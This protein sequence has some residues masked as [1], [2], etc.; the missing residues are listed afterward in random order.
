MKLIRLLPIVV[1]PCLAVCFVGSAAVAAF[2]APA[3]PQLGDSPPPPSPEKVERLRQAPPPVVKGVV[4]AFTVTVTTT[5]REE[6]R[7]F[8]NAVYFA[9]QDVPIAWSGNVASCLAGSTFAAFR[10]A[11][12]RR[13][14]YFRAM[15]GIPANIVFNGTF[16]TK[17]QQA[18]LMMSAANTLSHFPAPSWPCFTADGAEAAENSNL[19]LGSAGPDAVDGF[20]E[21][22]GSNNEAVGHRRWLLYPQTETMGTGD[23]PASGAN[24]AANAIWVFDGNFGGPRPATREAF[25]AWPPPGFV[26][27]AVVYPRWSFSFPDADFAG[28]TVS[29]S[30]NG[31]GI[32]VTVHTLVGGRGENTLVW[33][34][35]DLD[36]NPAFS[37]PRPAADTPFT[38]F[39]NNVLVG[40]TLRGFSYVVTVFDP[41]VPGPDAVLP[42][43]VG[44][45]SPPLSVPS[46]YNFAMVP[47]ATGYQ[48][49]QAHRSP[50]ASVEGAEQG[51]IN[52]ISNTSPGYNVVVSSP[53][54][55][56]SRAFHLA[57]P[58][59]EN[60]TLTLARSLLPGAGSQLQFKS[61]L[62]TAAAG[63]VAAVEV[64]LD[65][66][67]SWFEV[68]RQPGSGGSGEGSFTT[69]NVSLAAWAGRAVSIRFRYLHAGGSFFPQTTAGI[70]WYLDDIVVT[71]AEELTQP[72]D[73]STSG[74]SFDLTPA[75][76]TNLALLVR[77]ELF[78]AYPLEW[79]PAARVIAA[80][81]NNPPVAAC[82]NVTVAAGPDCLAAVTTAQV[83][84]GSSDP[85]GDPL[86]FSLSPPGPFPLG[87]TTVTL[88]AADPRGG[89]N[90]C[91]AT[92]TVVDQTPPSIACPPS[93][94][95]NLAIGV[96]N[97]LVTFAATATD[98]CSLP[99][100]V[101]TPPSGSV[102]P[103]GTNRVNCSATDG[104]GN[105][106]T[107]AF[108][109]TLHP[110]EPHDLA[111]SKIAAPKTVTVRIGGLPVTK[112]VSVAVQN[113]SRHPQTITN[114]QQLAQ[115]VT[116]EVQS[117]DSN[118]CPGR[119]AVLLTN[120]PQKRLPFTLKPKAK[121]TVFFA[122]TFDPGC[123]PRPAKGLGSEDYRYVAR[124]HH[125]AL[126]GQP[127]THPECDVCPRA[128]V[129]EPHPDGKL[130]DLGCG[131]KLPDGTFTHVLTD[132][133]L[134]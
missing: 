24:F 75:L 48:W 111:V 77:A 76:A 72:L 96:S 114:L 95:T 51:L 45:L 82:R 68:Y 80:G 4:P 131:K 66:G 25:V 124:V 34:P 19:A 108:N 39:I 21:D 84:N 52:V 79:G 3:S 17:A 129:A 69:R 10:D 132:L 50:F 120:A 121:L 73:A 86:S 5:N 65:E 103:L 106:A 12:A 110:P 35:S 36:P 117:L 94:A 87:P 105:T 56:G 71:G 127:D 104:A 67:N 112:R 27:H 62:G 13:I 28:A 15:A 100:I 57:H 130:R 88:T 116:L 43:I 90:S 97:A 47:K 55:S 54:A 85:D 42:V 89:S 23:V 53:V 101:C 18:A 29:L 32:P 64:S 41:A 9:S 8:F 63:Q 83:N 98:H 31:V 123:V 11:T 126:D 99:V 102:F 58:V 26:P 92:I 49:R 2:A 74:L 6:T 81:P 16:N 133:F 128:P 78:G 119:V 14:N 91:A 70:G 30:S 93:L 33:H 109:I 1:V 115:L 40:G 37:W 107:C 44:P 134:R 20:L 7:N 118:A 60:Q 59:A 22:Y 61:R 122:V 113:R 46:T 38:V 125:E